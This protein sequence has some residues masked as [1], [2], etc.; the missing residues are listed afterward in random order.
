MNLELFKMNKVSEHFVKERRAIME[1]KIKVHLKQL[2]PSL[3]GS[4]DI[5]ASK[6]EGSSTLTAEEAYKDIKN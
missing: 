2:M 4:A 3:V 5:L 6:S 1:N